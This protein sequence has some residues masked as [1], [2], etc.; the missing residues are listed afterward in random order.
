MPQRQCPVRFALAQP[1][2]VV[3]MHV[4]M[5]SEIAGGSAAAECPCT[6]TE[7]E[8]PWHGHSITHLV[9]LSKHEQVCTRSASTHQNKTAG[10][11][12]RA[13]EIGKAQHGGQ[14]D[15]PGAAFGLDGPRLTLDQTAWTPLPQT[16]TGQVWVYRSHPGLTAQSAKSPCIHHKAQL[17]PP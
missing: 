2:R 13:T 4:I 16:T 12:S 7:H 3:M 6:M 15:W 14:G 5:H 8:L 10:C 17:T 1:T 11:C 9:L